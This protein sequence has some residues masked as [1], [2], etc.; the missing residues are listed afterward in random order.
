MGDE[1]AELFGFFGPPP[2][3]GE[4]F[5]NFAGRLRRLKDRLTFSVILSLAAHAVLIGSMTVFRG[6]EPARESG[7]SFAEFKKSLR[8]AGAAFQD[9]EILASLLAEV[10]EED[11]F[12]AY[13]KDFRFDE[14][15]TESERTSATRLFLSEAL[16]R[17]KRRTGARSALDVPLSD[18]FGG[19]EEE[20]EVELEEGARL[21]R[22]KDALLGTTRFY[23]LS[24]DKRARI[25]ALKA[26]GPAAPSSEED[27]RIQDGRNLPR[28]PGEYLYRACPYERMLA[29]GSR[30]FYAV[31]GFPEVGDTELEPESED[32]PARPK[33]QGAA[34]VSR[35][36]RRSA[37]F[38][39]DLYAEFESRIFA[40]S[41]GPASL[42]SLGRRPRPDPRR[43]DDASGRSP[44][45][46]LRAGLPAAFSIPTIPI[47]PA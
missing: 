42:E 29:V 3:T 14:R 28:F 9:P 19:P 23:R 26:G 7:V 38:S 47:W 45:R 39:G 6:A 11:Y 16:S 21:F 5:R 32:S 2:R 22:M 34:F 31:R 10:T 46:S 30:H 20:S 43:A 24:R 4:R 18:F 35:P 13:E 37:G 25:D 1:R 12:E 27:V 36:G 40:V 41:G 44:G 17:F 33:N 8:D 15:L